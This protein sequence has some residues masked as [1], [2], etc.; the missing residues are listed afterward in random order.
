MKIPHQYQVTLL[1]PVSIKSPE[2][3]E[4]TNNSMEVLLKMLGIIKYSQSKNNRIRQKLKELLKKT[5]SSVS[6]KV[7]L[8]SSYSRKS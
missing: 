2:E 6:A 5:L 1:G 4:V 8:K 3:E 7:K